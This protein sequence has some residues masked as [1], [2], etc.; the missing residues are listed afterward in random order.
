MNFRNN[1]G[2]IVFLINS[3]GLISETILIKKGYLF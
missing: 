1:L 2:A 3:Q